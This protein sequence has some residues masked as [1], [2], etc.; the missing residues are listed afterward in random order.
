MVQAFTKIYEIPSF[1][2]IYLN[3]ISGN[4]PDEVNVYILETKE[5]HNKLYET[6]TI[7]EAESYIE[8]Y[9]ESIIR[10]DKF[11]FPYPDNRKKGWAN[12]YCRSKSP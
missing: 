3:L 2:K 9:L 6:N 8:G 5:K 11:C 7:P 1:G 12:I 10:N 4:F